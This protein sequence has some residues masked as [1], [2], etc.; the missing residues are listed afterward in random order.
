MI[1]TKIGAKYAIA[2]TNP[3]WPDI[4]YNGPAVFNGEF[5]GF[6]DPENGFERWYGFNI[7]GEKET[8][9]YSEKDII[10]ELK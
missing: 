7:E 9:F 4:T 3:A 2:F 5:N 1:P 10:G 6:D 8:L